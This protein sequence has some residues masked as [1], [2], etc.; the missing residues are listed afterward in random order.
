MR[1]AQIVEARVELRHPL[2]LVGSPQS[3]RRGTGEVGVHRGVR[4]AQFAGIG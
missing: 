3:A 2:R 1:L 4:G